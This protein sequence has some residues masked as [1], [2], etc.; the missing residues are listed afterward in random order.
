MTGAL[1]VAARHKE[2]EAYRPPMPSF[3]PDLLAIVEEVK[4]AKIVVFWVALSYDWKVRHSFKELAKLLDTVLR[5]GSPNNKLCTDWY[6]ALHPSYNGQNIRDTANPSWFNFKAQK[7]P[8]NDTQRPWLQRQP[9]LH[10]SGLE[11]LPV[12]SPDDL[13]TRFSGAIGFEATYMAAT[14]FEMEDIILQFKDQFSDD[15]MYV[16][17]FEKRGNDAYTIKVRLHGDD[18]AIM[19]KHTQLVPPNGTSI[20]LTLPGDPFN[21]DNVLYAQW[22][23][24]VARQT[25]DEYDFVFVSKTPTKY[26]TG[27]VPVP[28]R[29]QVSLRLSM[30]DYQGELLLNGITAAAW[31]TR[32]RTT[33]SD[34]EG[35]RKPFH[36]S[37]IVCGD[38][39]EEDSPDFYLDWAATKSTDDDSAVGTA[40]EVLWQIPKDYNTEQKQAYYLFIRGCR[41]GVLALEGL[42]G[43]G[44]SKVLGGI[45]CALMLMGYKI[46][47]S[48]QSNTGVCEVFA[49]VVAYMTGNFPHLCER[50]LR[51]GANSIE[52]GLLGEIEKH[53]YGVTDKD[54]TEGT[55]RI[56]DANIKY[57]AAYRQAKWMMENPDHPLTKDNRAWR[58]AQEKY[59]KSYAPNRPLKPKGVDSAQSKAKNTLFDMVIEPD[60][61]LL[62][63]ATA[64]T[65]SKLDDVFSFTADALIFDELSQATESTFLLPI[66]QQPKIKAMLICGDT[67]QLP[68][69]VHS[70]KTNPYGYQ[71]EL[72][73]L[74]RL[75]RGYHD[76]ALVTLVRNYRCHDEIIAL[77]SDIVYHG[78]MISG[79]EAGKFPY[80]EAVEKLIGQGQICNILNGLFSKSYSRMAGHGR[81]WWVKTPNA[82]T[83]PLEQ[84]DS[85]WNPRG[86]AAVV[87]LASAFVPF[88]TAKR[89]KVITMYSHEATKLREV[90]PLGVEV[91]T[92]D[93]FQGG[94]EDFII[95]HFSAAWSSKHRENPLGFTSD[96]RRLNVA[97][98]RAKQMMILVGNSD[99][100]ADRIQE[101]EGAKEDALPIQDRNKVRKYLVRAGSVPILKLVAMVE[102]LKQVV[103]WEE[104]NDPWTKEEAQM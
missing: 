61:L 1:L 29:S 92:V 43:T 80:N 56:K 67:K 41:A 63:G 48:A 50:M 100:W 32:M 19:H 16:A 22:V 75:I 66:V 6:W 4:C 91:R 55:T 86:A 14:L 62:V 99:H 85:S 65:A 96:L 94:E 17:T 15:Q 20:M 104:Y 26:H 47:I 18:I 87:E 52:D 95:V 12:W 42:P 27:G 58:E 51:L 45:A 84:G 13:K 10:K 78:R 70:K 49:K 30:T 31:S 54:L 74:E 81:V 24:K 34:L 68:P 102:R 25:E 59:D 101:Y 90:L 35:C 69:V 93:S 103:S 71:L 2:G 3:S 83:K 60:S 39:V 97:I 21:E 98:T 79:H 40:H 33:N 76:R 88:F 36:V 38:L 82:I 53:H 11:F 28:P 89:I 37:N 23:G 9:W 44:K 46:L 77:A 72:S 73:P 57:T 5:H 64:A 7:F 8:L